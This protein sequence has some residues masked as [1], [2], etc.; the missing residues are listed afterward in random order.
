MADFFEDF[1]TVEQRA[2]LKIACENSLKA[3][4]KVMHYYN[5]GAHFEFMPFHNQV[6]QALEDRANYKNKKNLLLNLPV[7]FG[8]SQIVEYFIGWTFARNKNIC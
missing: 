6:I 1:N 8:K 5:T 4:I 2:V 7:G 3:F